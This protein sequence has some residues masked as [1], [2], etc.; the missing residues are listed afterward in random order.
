MTKYAIVSFNGGEYSPKID[1][2]ADTEKY[3]GGCRKLENMI[4]S[5]FGGAEKRPGTEFI[6]TKGAFNA[7]LAA[8]VA[9]KNIV[10]CWE[11][12][13]AVTDYNTLLS[14][15]TCHDNDVMCLENNIVSDVNIS[16]LSRA[17]CYENN[18]VFIEGESV[19]I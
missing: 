10:C 7:I 2:R 9:H 12:T 8:I 5:V 17:V 6:T 15:I 11:N 13:P 4:P 3:A 18:M 16:F 19:Y 1:A 14:Q